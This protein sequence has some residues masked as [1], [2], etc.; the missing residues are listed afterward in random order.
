MYGST[1][2]CPLK[3]GVKNVALSNV[4]IVLVFGF[5]VFNDLAFGKMSHEVLE[6]RSSTNLV[7]INT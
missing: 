1:I 2:P 5:T 6:K 7:Y 4:L 3:R